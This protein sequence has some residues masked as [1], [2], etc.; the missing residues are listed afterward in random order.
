M[1]LCNY[2]QNCIIRYHYFIV[3]ECDTVSVPESPC[4]EIAVNYSD[5]N[6][7]SNWNTICVQ[8]S[9]QSC[10]DSMTIM[11]L[12]F[13]AIAVK[14]AVSWHCGLKTSNVPISSDC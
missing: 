8:V 12:A 14:D 7:A 2:K 13:C 9:S 3:A 5:G 1:I 11:L 10:F 6:N 4:P